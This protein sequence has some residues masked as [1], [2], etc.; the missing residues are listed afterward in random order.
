MMFLDDS[1]VHRVGL[2][3]DMTKKSNDL[4]LH[5]AGIFNFNDFKG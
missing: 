2:I 5:Q 4:E 1:Q 3:D